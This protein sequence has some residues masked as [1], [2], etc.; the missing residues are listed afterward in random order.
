MKGWTPCLCRCHL[1]GARRTAHRR[2]VRLQV[3][4]SKPFVGTKAEMYQPMS[5]VAIF[6]HVKGSRYG[7]D[8][9]PSLE[10]PWVPLEGEE[11]ASSSEAE[12]YS[13]YFWGETAA[14]PPPLRMQKQTSNKADEGADRGE[15]PHAAAA[16][17][18]EDQVEVS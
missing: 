9:F 13:N 10:L 7:E 2:Q 18:G 16:A 5:K 4:A 6:P 3:E 1:I 15:R 8:L 12:F 11:G 14:D 17:A